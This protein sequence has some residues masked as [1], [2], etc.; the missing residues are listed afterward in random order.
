MTKDN[1][2]YA[3]LTV[4][5]DFSP[6]SVTTK[7]G[8]E[9]S[10]AWK[11]G[12]RKERTHL[13]RKF[14]RWSIES[15][16]E[17]SASLEDHLKDVLKQLMPNAEQIRQVGTE[18][19]VWIQLVGIFYKDYPGFG[20]DKEVISGLAQLNIGLGGTIERRRVPSTDNLDALLNRRGKDAYGLEA[21]DRA[22]TL[23][24]HGDDY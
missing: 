6:E 10:E 22:P 18:Y 5:G 7:L 2:Q 12:E 21:Q 20:M 14:S 4:V 1:E 13:E 3:Y 8:L 23:P 19:Q 24:H 9:P 15:R 11:K 17:R 16:L